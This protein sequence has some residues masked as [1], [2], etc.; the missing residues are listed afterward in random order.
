MRVR[1]GGLVASRRCI[2][3]RRL[4]ASTAFA[5]MPKGM[6]GTWKLNGAAAPR[7]A[8]DPRPRA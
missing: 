8:R 3:R 4:V 7:L 5:Q 2:R 6:A 1:T